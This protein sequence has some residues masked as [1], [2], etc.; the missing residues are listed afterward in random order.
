MV[1]SSSYIVEFQISMSATSDEKQCNVKMEKSGNMED[2]LEGFNDGVMK[3]EETHT[4]EDS[5]CSHGTNFVT[6][7]TLDFHLETSHGPNLVD[8]HLL[9]EREITIPYLHI[10]MIQ[11]PRG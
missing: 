7:S 3:E 10:I 1:H 4:H 6:H 9:I 8:I 2:G 11:K 5:T